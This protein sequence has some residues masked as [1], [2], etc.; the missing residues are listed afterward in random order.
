M[1]VGGWRSLAART[2]R[3][4][5]AEG[6]NPSPPTKTLVQSPRHMESLTLRGPK[7]WGSASAIAGPGNG[8]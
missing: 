3:D 2:V 1:R 6:S 4:R 5:E 7:Y 8:I